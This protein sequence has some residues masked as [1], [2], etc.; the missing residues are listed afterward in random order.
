MYRIRYHKQFTNSSPT[1]GDGD[2]EEVNS[3]PKKTNYYEIKGP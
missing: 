1:L 3:S 2:W